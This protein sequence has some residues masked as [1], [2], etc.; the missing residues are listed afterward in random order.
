MVVAPTCFDVE[1]LRARLHTAAAGGYHGFFRIAGSMASEPFDFESQAE[2]PVAGSDV[3]PTVTRTVVAFVGRTERGPLN[4]PVNLSSFDEYRRAFGGHC[5]FS[6]V[7]FAVQ[8]F[9]LHGGEAAVVVRVANR[10]TRSILD[11]PA[12]PEVL[13][14]QARQPGSREFL[15][16]SIDYDRVEQQPQRFNLVVQRLGRPGSQLVA[17]QE[18]F[19][20]LSM[21]PADERFFVDA[22]H[23]SELVRLVGPLPATR[24]DATRPA[25]PG[26]P[27]PYLAATAH[28]SDGEELTDYDVIGSNNEGT[29]IF[30][31]DRCE[32]IDL[33][34]VPSPP[35][36][37][38]G[39]TSFVAAT[40][41][42]ERRRAMLVWDPPWAWASVSAA[43]FGVRTSG[44][45]SRH[46]LTYFP[47]VRPRGDVGRYREGIPA[48]GVV[49]GALARADRAGVWHDMPAE[50]TAL[51]GNLAPLAEVTAKQAAV[52][53][54]AG[55][56]T[57]MRVHP[58]VA[59][60]R[61][62]VSYA[63]AAAV[64]TAWQR[65]GVARLVSFVL[66]SIERHT[67]W[68]LSADRSN[69]VASE[70]ER[71]V[72][73]FLTRLYERGALVGNTSNQAFFVR[74]ARFGEA[75]AAHSDV[76]V[77]LRVGFAPERANEFL[78][79]DFRYRESAAATEVVAVPDAERHL[80]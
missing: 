75:D 67:R 17:D 31:L 34:C 71:Q 65:L 26:E 64:A 51:K 30:A 12:G 66:R 10:A 61:G 60:L 53:H 15:R 21:D 39:S 38:L 41:Y 27:I 77:A 49:A 70:L 62:N 5:A 57:F 48:C 4:E 36:R 18:L 44:R 11:V 54:R 58:G 45:V 1:I 43:L 7:S 24:P 20:S 13:R 73:I 40:R 33:L 69:D 9:F 63:G 80:G 37:D 72:W 78:I 3:I 19:E 16:V 2:R 23:E 52:L 14:L 50:E 74:S 47:R 42:C 56:N 35:G 68:V 29:G 25:R 6:F 32:Q 46:A 28:G 59:A 8:H 76:A 22:L 79:Y 55:V